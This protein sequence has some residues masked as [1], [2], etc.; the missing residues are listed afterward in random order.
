MV[1]SL[2]ILALIFIVGLVTGSFLNVVILRTISG[3]S[4]VFPGSKCPKCQTPLKWY[5]NIPILSYLFLR[6][7]CAFCGE[8]ISIQYPIIEFLTGIIY[9]WMFIKFCVPFDEYFGLS[10]MNPINIVQVITYAFI[11]IV[12]SLFIVIAGTDIKEMMVADRHTYAL[13]GVGIGYSI[14][15]SILTL[16]YYTK[17]FGKPTIDWGFFVTCPILY[18]IA[19]AV[20]CFIFMEIIRRGAKFMLKVESFGEGDSYIAAGIGAVIGALYGISPLVSDFR[21]IF[22]ILI[23]I[24]VLSVIIPAIILFPKYIYNLFKAKN[25]FQLGCIITFAIYAIAYFLAREYGWVSNNIAL[26]SSTIV[27][28]LLGILLCGEILHGI[29]KNPANITTIPFGPALVLSAFLVIAFLP[30]A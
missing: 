15:M 23:L 4:I 10:V 3:E 25:M 1:F 9:L 27:L 30:I 17:Q 5:H 24:F 13:I 26:Y 22:Y 29:K 14:I 18:A 11:L 19:G 7:K 2:T 28:A 6:G 16:L 12:C 8:R 21:Q 20:V